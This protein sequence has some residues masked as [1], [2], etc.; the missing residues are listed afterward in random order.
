M[1][2]RTTPTAC[3]APS[4]PSLPPF[5][6]SAAARALTAAVLTGGLL[7]GG[8]T[9]ALAAPPSVPG[10]ALP[11]AA[12]AAATTVSVSGEGRASAAPDTVV[13][14]A[15]VEA[16]EPTAKRA[17]AAQSKAAGALLAA[18]RAQGIDDSDVRTESLSLNAVHEHTDRASKLI[19]YQAGQSFSIKIRDIGRTGA[20]MEAVTDATGDAGRINGVAFDVADP[21]VLRARARE[22]A[23]AEARSKAEQY[24]RLSGHRLGRLV[25]LAETEGGTHRPLDMPVAAFSEGK[26]PVAPGEVQ[27]EVT[28]TAVYELE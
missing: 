5:L 13:L 27:E 18:V 25:S 14:T 22:A 26:V 7:I 9:P 1:P 6:P 19:G 20:V 16:T 4:S 12:P 10:T 24:A 8:A 28:V 3:T 17:L 23:H 21:S 2:V 15:G 11:A